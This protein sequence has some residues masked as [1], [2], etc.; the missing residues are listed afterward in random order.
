[1]LTLMTPTPPAAGDIATLRALIE[2]VADPVSA[3]A[4]ID[5]LVAAAAA[6]KT[7]R[8]AVLVDKRMDLAVPTT[9]RDADRLFRRP[10]FP[11]PAQRCALTCMLSSA[12]CSGGSG[13]PATVS[14]IC[15]QIPRTLQRLKR[16]YTVVYGPYS[17][18]QSCQRHPLFST[19]MIPLKIRRLF[20][21]FGPGR[22]IGTRGSIFA[23]CSSF[24]RTGSLSSVGPRFV[25][26]TC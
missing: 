13:E 20:C 25:R 1:M 17:G 18:G 4:R 2:L 21:G 3:S 8:A 10:P 9:P 11:P 12:T 6:A 23:H 15:C 7:A 19:W 5:E 14:K 22:F 16:L 24:N 26:P